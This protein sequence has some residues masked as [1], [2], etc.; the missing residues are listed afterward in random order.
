MQ[1]EISSNLVPQ[2][3]HAQSLPRVQQV[4]KADAK[5]IVFDGD[6]RSRLQRGINKVADAVAVT[7]GPRG[8]SHSASQAR[9]KCFHLMEKHTR[10]V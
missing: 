1:P 5:E 2:Q 7:L 9:N 4:V 10:T 8:A 6:S 3:P